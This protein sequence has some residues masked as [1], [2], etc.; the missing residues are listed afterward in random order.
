VCTER[1]TA[2]EVRRG[3]NNPQGGFVVAGRAERGGIDGGTSGNAASMR[4]TAV[5][6]MV[7]S[8]AI[9]AATGS[10]NVGARVDSSD[11]ASAALM[12]MIVI[13]MR[14]PPEGRGAGPQ[15][16]FPGPPGGRGRGVRVVITRLAS[17]PAIL[18]ATAEI[19]AA[20]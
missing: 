20:S 4:R 7:N 11:V 14:V 10:L 13:S 1:G 19:A 6:S 12:E 18:A 15:V 9:L 17:T 2:V 8:S 5:E 3:D 16:S